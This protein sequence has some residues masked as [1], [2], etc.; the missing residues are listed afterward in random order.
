MYL[1]CT[2]LYYKYEMYLSLSLSS[3]VISKNSL[4]DGVRAAPQMYKNR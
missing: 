3:Y 1:K 2:Q 4:G